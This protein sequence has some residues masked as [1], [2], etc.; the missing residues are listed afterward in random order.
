MLL[1]KISTRAPKGLDKE[2]TKAKT[3][4]L[5]AYIGEQ[6]KILYAGHERSLLIILQGVDASGKDGVVAGVFTGLNPLGVSVASFKV[7]NEREKAHDFLWR[8]HPVCPPKGM[9][10]IF[11]RSHYEDILVPWANDKISPKELKHRIE[12]INAFEKILEHS[13]TTI[14]KLYLHVSR[15]E[16]KERL[17][18][19]KRNPKKY[20]KH[21][22]D[23]WDMRKKWDKYMHAYD[24][25]FKKCDQPAWHIVPADQNWYKDFVVAG[26]VCKALRK[27]K[28]KY[29]ALK[30]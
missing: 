28:L 30:R 12:D 2:K 19:R 7:P 10:H 13:G 4:K 6:Q 17:E 21:N 11:N 18:E 9:I 3:Q 23:D 20:W 5:L 8:I 26:L 22:D 29:P 15:D 14:I 24:L 16:Q 27:M 1:N 25:I